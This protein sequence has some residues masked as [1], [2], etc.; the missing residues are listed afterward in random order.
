MH[1]VAG[2]LIGSH[3]ATAE[4]IELIEAGKLDLELQGRTT[5]TSRQGHEQ[6]GVEAVAAGPNRPRGG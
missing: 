6:P 2:L 5:M 3:P 4:V 1:P